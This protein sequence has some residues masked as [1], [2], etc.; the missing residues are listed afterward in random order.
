MPSPFHVDNIGALGHLL[1]T[2][3]GFIIEVLTEY[4]PAGT[5]VKYSSAVDREWH[6][7]HAFVFAFFGKEW[8]E[9]D[10]LLLPTPGQERCRVFFAAWLAGSSSTRFV[11]FRFFWIFALCILES[12]YSSRSVTQRQHLVPPNWAMNN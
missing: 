2:G 3:F 4:L 12:S 5:A 9:R 7:A 11:F 1:S 10:A 8:P 6:G